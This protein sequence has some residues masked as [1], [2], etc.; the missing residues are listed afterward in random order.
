M[1]DVAAVPSLVLVADDVI[2]VVAALP[3]CSVGLFCFG[4]FCFSV[5]IAVEVVVLPSP[6]SSFTSP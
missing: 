2:L 6:S 3:W 5:L 1:S 4:A